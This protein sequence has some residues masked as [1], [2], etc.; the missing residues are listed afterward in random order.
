[1]FDGQEISQFTYFQ[2]AGGV[3]L[4][5]ISAELTYGLERIAMAL[6][7][8]DSMFDLEWSEGVKYRDVRLREEIEQS[9]YVFGQV[10]MPQAEFAAFHREMFDRYYKFSEQLLQSGLIW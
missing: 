1:M 6:Q 9:K 5:P 8:V 7:H 10:N 3:E 4:A 2:Q